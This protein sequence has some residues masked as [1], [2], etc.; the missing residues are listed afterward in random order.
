MSPASGAQASTNMTTA[1]YRHTALIPVA[2]LMV[3]VVFILT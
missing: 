1:N 3:I 2:A